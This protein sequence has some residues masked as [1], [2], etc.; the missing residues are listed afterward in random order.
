MKMEQWFLL[1]RESIALLIVFR[2]LA[3]LIEP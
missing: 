2:L 1:L 3:V